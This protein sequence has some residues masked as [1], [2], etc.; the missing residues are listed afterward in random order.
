MTSDAQYLVHLVEVEWASIT[1]RMED[2]RLQCIQPGRGIRIASFQVIP[3][4]RLP[5]YETGDVFMVL[6]EVG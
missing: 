5:P 2:A 1:R 4:D 6:E 3:T